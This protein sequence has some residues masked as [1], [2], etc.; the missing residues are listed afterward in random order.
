MDSTYPAKTTLTS[1][2]HL[3]VP[4][5]KDPA[6]DATT[7]TLSSSNSSSAHLKSAE[8]AK[9]DSPMLAELNSTL[10]AMQASLAS[11]QESLS[12]FDTNVAHQQAQ[13]QATVDELRN[14]KKTEDADRADLKVKMKTL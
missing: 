13:L 10:T 7:V 2:Q 5:L 11:M 9:K 4:L 3:T 12:L 1:S 6:N 14:K 8:A